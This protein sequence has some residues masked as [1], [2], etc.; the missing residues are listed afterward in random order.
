MTIEYFLKGIIIGFSV[1]APVGPIGVL[2]IRRTL[3]EGR[4][5]G[6]LTG[7]GAAAA[8]T[9][10]GIIAGF[11]IVAITTALISVE[12]W[13]KLLGG[14]FLLYLGVTLFIAKPAENA[15][16]V[17]ASGLLG[18]FFSTFFLTVT[19][20]VT[21]LSFLAIF[22]GLGLGK[23]GAANYIDSMALVI[24]VFIG[25]TL[26]WMTLS[27]GVGFFREKF[28]AAKLVWVNRISGVTVAAFGLLA[29]FS[30]S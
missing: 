3:S 7:I 2:C 8:D 13:M 24:G 9:L 16:T 30:L 17:R 11:G 12:F 21:I 29:L 6:L 14:L 5:S 20:P 4:L 27:L 26:W 18:N 15:A 22:A 28:D 1:A 19:N 23:S 25:S 10:Y